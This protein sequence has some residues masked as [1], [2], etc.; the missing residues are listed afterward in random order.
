MLGLSA[1]E[2]HQA[3]M[4]I[5]DVILFL[6]RNDRQDLA[7]ELDEAARM[8]EVSPGPLAAAWLEPV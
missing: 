1:V 6:R 5:A 2:R 4:D 8:A 7:I 3:A